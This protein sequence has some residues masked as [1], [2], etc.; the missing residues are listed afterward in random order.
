MTETTATES[1]GGGGGGGQKPDSQSAFEAPSSPVGA[2]RHAPYPLTTANTTTADST[3][4]SGVGAASTSKK[5]A[6][7]STA[8]VSLGDAH[9]ELS[10]LII[11]GR[12]SSDDVSMTKSILNEHASLKEKVEKL[13]SLLGRSAKAQREAKVDLDASQKRLTQAMREIDRLNQKL[14]KLQTRPSRTSRVVEAVSVGF[15]Q[16]TCTVFFGSFLF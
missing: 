5:A 4:T 2:A 6:R 10:Q 13:K 12:I 15:V 9:E 7:R 3:N 1:N 8:T 11:G 16:K 14:D